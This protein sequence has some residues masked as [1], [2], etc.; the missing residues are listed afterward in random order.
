MSKQQDIGSSFADFA[1]GLKGLAETIG[2]ALRTG[3][4]EVQY[5]EELHGEKAREA[6]RK[7][8]RML[9]P[10]YQPTTIKQVVDAEALR[11]KSQVLAYGL[12]ETDIEN[13]GKLKCTGKTIEPIK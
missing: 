5:D 12:T 8:I 2:E 1:A 6:H 3:M 10:R 9:E 4:F 7:T 13:V 11:L